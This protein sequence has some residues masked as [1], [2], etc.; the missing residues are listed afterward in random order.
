MNGQG[1]L[2]QFDPNLGTL[3]DLVESTGDAAS[4]GI[5]HTA[6]VASYAK[7]IGDQCV[8]TG[9]VAL[10]LSFELQPFGLRQNGDAVIANRTAQENF[11][12]GP[13]TIGGKVDAL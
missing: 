7:Y 4:R 10:D 11:V 1:T 13:G 3:G 2:V 8:Q 12:S 9:A 5:A 6:D